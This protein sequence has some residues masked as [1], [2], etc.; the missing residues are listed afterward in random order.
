ML[1]AYR[2]HRKCCPHLRE[3]RNCLRCGCPVWVDGRFKGKRIHRSLGTSDSQKAQQ[4]V[5]DW[6]VEGSYAG[7]ESRVEALSI[8]QA[9]LRFLT[10]LDV[11]K[12]P[13]ST[14]RKYQL[15]KKQMNGFAQVRGFNFLKQ[16]DTDALDEFR[17]TWK[18]GAAECQLSASRSC[19]AIRAF[20]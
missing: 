19:S 11:R 9:W 12:L 20:G 8:E 13:P 18:D 15:L 3:G 7:S 6:E 5:R 4:T 10:D 2:R 14:I 16:I 17:S 1:Y